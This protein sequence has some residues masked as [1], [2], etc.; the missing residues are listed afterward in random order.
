LGLSSPVL[1]KSK[2]EKLLQVIEHIEDIADIQEIMPVLTAE[3]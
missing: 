3:A 1:G 2:A